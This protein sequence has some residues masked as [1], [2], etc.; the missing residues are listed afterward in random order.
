MVN[1]SVPVS[2]LRALLKKIKQRVS[3]WRES[4][5]MR[6]IVEE[7]G[8]ALLAAYEERERLKAALE[9]ANRE[10]INLN[11]ESAGFLLGMEPAA[12]AAAKTIVDRLISTAEAGLVNDYDVAVRE[13]AEIILGALRASAAG[14]EET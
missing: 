5:R 13:Y 3:S 11:L 7:H 12:N 4:Y 14:G 10:A 8:E 9:K 1:D 2:E 6:D